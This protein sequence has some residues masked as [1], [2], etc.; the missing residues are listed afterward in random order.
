MED[1]KLLYIIG[2]ILVVFLIATSIGVIIFIQLKPNTSAPI[3]N[4]N[5]NANQIDGLAGLPRSDDLSDQNRLTNT[6]LLALEKDKQFISS[7]WELTSLD[8]TPQTPNYSL[9]LSNVKEQVLNY[10]DFSRRVD[11]ENTLPKLAQNGFVIINDPFNNKKA[12]WET[13]YKTIRDNQLPILITSDSIIGLYQNTLGVIYK[14]IEQEIFYPSLWSLLQELRGEIKTRY[15]F[16]FKEF[17]IVDDLVTEANRLELAQISVA[18][19]LLKPEKSQIKEAIVPDSGFFTPTEAEFYKSE[20][21]DYLQKEVAEEISLI[22]KK[23]NIKQKSP[24][25]LYQKDYSKFNIPPQY[26][27]SEKLKN[28]YLAITWLNETLFPLWSTANDC[29]DCLLD[30]QDHKINFVAAL[31]LSTDLA[32]NQEL[33]NQWA[34]IYKSISFFK[35]L[36]SNLTYLD[37][38]RAVEESFESQ[39]TI[40]DLFTADTDV[41]E[42]RIAILQDKLNSYKFPVSLGGGKENRQEIGLRLLRNYHL[43]ENKLFNTLIVP[44]TTIYQDKSEKVPTVVP[45]TACYIGQEINRCSPTALDLFSL[46]GNKQ[47]ENIIAQTKNN[48][49]DNYQSNLNQFKQELQTFDA[50]TWHDNAYMASLSS[51]QKLSHSYEG[52]PTFMNTDAWKN[53]SLNTSLGAWVDAH[54][55]INF[56]KTALRENSV[57]GSFFPYG[58]IEPEIEL[59]REL[60][61]NVEMIIDGFTNLRIISEQSKSYERLENLKITL[62]QIVNIVKKELDNQDLINDDYNFINGFNKH[63]RSFIG[64]IKKENIQ[65]N[66]TFKYLYQNTL[67]EESVNG[68]NYAIVIYPKINGEIFFAIGPVF[69][70]SEKNRQNTR[71]SNWQESFQP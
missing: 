53:K 50:N 51:L 46:L 22:T 43:L 23:S 7:F 35:G 45:F 42:E 21:P 34:N 62:Q 12:D 59:Y 49:F 47:A 1:K 33:K 70:Y 44:H 15:E 27:T 9:P 66:Y 58:Y 25:F 28:Y 4:T 56:E 71:V 63:I 39:A 3:V 16:R 40:N 26:N 13:S 41:V 65:N 68:L 60:L 24:I 69:D 64:D 31:L 30:K 55:E 5:D 17:G 38:Q 8:Y 20:V 37:Y 54:R 10:R 61:A 32:K 18:L 52:Y 6:Q 36:E 48:I 29:A 67:L 14:E 19:E 11:I 2:I 57:L